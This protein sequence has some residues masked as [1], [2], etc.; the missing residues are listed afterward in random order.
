MSKLTAMGKYNI[1]PKY[2]AIAIGGSAGSFQPITNILANIPSDFPLPIFLCL[3]RLKHVKHGFVE[4]LSIK[5]NKPVA[6]PTDKEPIKKGHVYLA[7]ANYHMCVEEGNTMSLSTEGLINNSRP[8]I[9]LTLS[10][11]ANNYKSRLIGILMSGA[12][13]D[14]AEGMYFVKRNGGTTIVQ[15]PEES[16]I[17]TMP[18]SAIAATEID[19]VLTSEEIVEF[20]VELASSYRDIRIR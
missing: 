2:S 16:M 13:K 6:E 18:A 4:A 8:A 20:L 19:L 10:S 9:D 14:G 12:N 17:N 1:S 15:D 7:P 5:S 11:A 3:H